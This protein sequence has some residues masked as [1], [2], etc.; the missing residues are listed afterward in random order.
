MRPL[1]HCTAVLGALLLLVSGCASRKAPKTFDV[2]AMLEAAREF[3]PDTA[4]APGRELLAGFDVSRGDKTHRDGDAVLLGIFVEKD[5]KETVRYMRVGSRFPR[6]NGSFDG[7]MNFAKRRKFEFDWPT[8]ETV[9]ELFDEKGER[10]SRR[11]GGI[12]LALMDSGL[13]RSCE[14]A[15]AIRARRPDLKDADTAGLAEAMTDAEMEE[16]AMGWG[17]LIA[18]SVSLQRN[19]IFNKM[20]MGSI[21]KPP[22]WKM[23][24]GVS[25]GLGQRQGHHPTLSRV[26]LGTAGLGGI[27]MPAYVVPLVLE[28][29]ND[30][31]MLFDLT[32]V[33]VVPPL[34]LCGGLVSME[35]WHPTKAG[36]RVHVRLLGAE[37]GRNEEQK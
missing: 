10:L 29:N 1:P 7:T 25:I 23:L 14:L 28:I 9:I 37:R 17:S 33:P 31:A 13:F 18:M 36:I 15:D 21:E 35:A 30:E 24:L 8:C 19:P 22:F 32:V 34:E 26:T 20:L 2:G 3:D 27:E 11:A 4:F 12:P 16:I 5:G 6:V